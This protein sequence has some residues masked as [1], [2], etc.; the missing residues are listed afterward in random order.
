LKTKKITTK[1]ITQASVDAF[2]KKLEEWSKALP[3]E[4]RSLLRLLIDR[5]TSVNVADLGDYDLTAKV[6]PDGEQVFKSLKKAAARMPR[7]GWY[8]GRDGEIWL[9]SRTTRPG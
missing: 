7:P 8:K 1:R 4:E 3:K 6:R 2:S 5:A 9:R